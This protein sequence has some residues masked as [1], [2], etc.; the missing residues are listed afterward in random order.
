MQI[1]IDHKPHLHRVT[2]DSGFGHLQAQ[3]WKSCLPDFISG[4]GERITLG[5]AVA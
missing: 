1:S 4:R 2:H 3:L 5:R